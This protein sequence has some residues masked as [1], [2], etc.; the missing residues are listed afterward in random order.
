MPR[1]AFFFLTACRDALNKMKEVYIKNPHM[2][3]PNSVDPRLEEVRQSIE[4]LQ[5]EAHK[6]E[7]C[8]YTPLGS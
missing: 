4:K 3:D 7:V 6:Y 5:L 1:H 2:G 8:I